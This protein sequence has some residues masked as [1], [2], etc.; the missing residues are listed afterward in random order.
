MGLFDTMLFYTELCEIL[1]HWAGFALFS[2]SKAVLIKEVVLFIVKVDM[3][4][5]GR[6]LPSVALE[7]GFSSQVKCFLYC[8][9]T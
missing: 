5:N 7:D 4:Q 3:V 6:N 9:L 8:W 1:S 2:L